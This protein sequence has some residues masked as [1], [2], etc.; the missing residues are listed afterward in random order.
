MT[1]MITGGQRRHDDEVQPWEGGMTEDPE[2][3]SRRIV[4]DNGWVL[5]LLEY[6]QWLQEMINNPCNHVFDTR[7]NAFVLRA[8]ADMKKLE[9]QI[10]RKYALCL[11]RLFLIRNSQALKG[12]LGV[13][14]LTIHEPNR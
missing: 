11:H 12:A 4:Q 3:S 9:L 7:A 1:C 5:S 2:N 10:S 6:R 13:Y 8:Q 14:G